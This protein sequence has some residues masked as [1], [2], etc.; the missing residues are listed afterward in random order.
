MFNWTSDPSSPVKI[1]GFLA[2]EVAEVIP[3]AVGGA[4]KDAV[5]E[6]G[7]II[8]QTIM[9]TTFIEYIIAS[10]KNALIRIDD[11]ESM[12]ESQRLDIEE[13]SVRL[14]AST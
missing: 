4:E 13:L 14:S 5:D 10:L 3:D 7:N 12:V 1:I 11:L 2:H 9:N 8:P 6:Y